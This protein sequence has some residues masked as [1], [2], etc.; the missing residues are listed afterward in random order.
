MQ[1]K[2]QTN[3]TLTPQVLVSGQDGVV[4]RFALTA[5]PAAMAAAQQ[6]VAELDDDC[7]AGVI[8][9]APA[10][11]SVKLRF[12]PAR[13]SRSDL[14]AEA[15]KMASRIVSARATLPDPVRRWTI[16]VA[17][18]GENGPRLEEIAR[19]AGCSSDAAVAQICEADLRVL[20]IGFA[21]GQ[22]YIG[23][24]PETW[25]MPRLSQIVP[26]VPAGAVVVAVRQIVLFTAGSAT[27]W[28]Q[29]GRSVFRNF[30]PERDAPTLLRA[31]DAVRFQ[32]VSA[33]EIS[34]L[35]QADDGMGGARLEVL[36]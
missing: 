33:S 3:E 32:P 36:R 35:E 22:P 31:G 29:A 27:G 5:E 20:A 18:G 7:P 13:T 11:V 12:D 1:Q 8:E 23:L 15:L 17:F 34:V 10:L 19:E 28:R 30:M 16:P 25:N 4:I 24:L 9:I 2:S 6:L 21:P 14:I 26:D